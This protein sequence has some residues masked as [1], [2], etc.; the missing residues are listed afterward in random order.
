M[1]GEGERIERKLIM[2]TNRDTG[3]AKYYHEITKH[4]YESL[5]GSVHALDWSNQPLEYKIYRDLES[6]PLPADLHKTDKKGLSTL[7]GEWKFDNRESLID[8]SKLVHILYYSGGITKK[9]IGARGEHL[10]RAAASAGA[11]YPVE[12][13]V[14]C[15]DLTDLRAGVYHFN[16]AGFSLHKLRKGDYREI[17]VNA[18]GGDQNLMNSPASLVF[19]GLTL[20]TAWKY[21]AR[22]YR[23]HFWDCG[24]MV[25][26]SLAAAVA[27]ELSIKVLMGFV[28]N[29]MNQ[30]LGIDGEQEKSLCLVPLGFSPESR[31]LATDSTTSVQSPPDLNPDVVPLSRSQVEF[32]E[33]EMM[34]SA[35]LLTDSEEV[36]NWRGALPARETAEVQNELKKLNALKPNQFPDDTLEDVILSRGSSRMFLRKAIPFQNLS[37]ILERATHTFPSDWLTKVSLFLNSIYL[38]V[39]GVEDLASGAYV[40][41]PERSGLE[42]LKTGNFRGEA[43]TLCL[44]QDLGGDSSVTVFFLADLEQVL[45]RYGNRGY[46][47]AQMEAAIIAGKMYL[48]AYGLGLG[49]SGL[50]FFD[51]M[52]VEFFSPHASGKDA[53][54]VVALGVPPRSTGRNVRIV[55][56]APGED[57]RIP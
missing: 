48:A 4:S 17:L 47:L 29:D 51:D 55:R 21:R 24:V 13:Y 54:F 41:H 38:S 9:M 40:Y 6:I 43:A 53:I 34:H 1:L 3:I 46:R 50:T 30:L 27:Q 57:I 56:V 25:S 8:L 39:H 37:T 45:G 44:G 31:S 7:S 14:V 2:A 22:S 11:L 32:S 23:Y 33:I 15:S 49:A 19:T 52:V 20:R 12:I 18:S 36:K 35:S 28:D 5:Q 16:P 10:F 26:H 42:L